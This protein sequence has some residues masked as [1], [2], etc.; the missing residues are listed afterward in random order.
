VK[1]PP[2]PVVHEINT[3]V[4]LR[5]LAVA[6]RRDVRLGDVP[7]DAW[8]AVAGPGIDAV[9]LMGVWQRSP[10][11]AA[12][13]RE[14]PAMAAAQRAALPDVTADDVVGSA[15]CIRDYVVDEH[16]GGDDGLAAARAALAARG[17]ALVLDF[18]PNH[19]APDHPW[20]LEHPERFVPGTADD[21][22]ADPDGYLAVGDAVIARGRDPYFPA[23][24]EVLQLDASRPDVR[25][26]AA[27]TVLSIAA[28]CDGVRCD[29]AMLVLDDVFARTWGAR[30]SV[31]PTADGGPGYWP[32]VIG[33]VR[34]VHPDFA[35]WAEAY[36]DLEPR[37][38]EEGFD[39]CYDK[40]LYDRLVRGEA[41]ASV[42]EHL[43]ADPASQ[44]HT[45]RFVENHDE[46]RVAS[47]LAPAAARAAAVVALTVPGVALLHEGQEVGRQV[48]VP[49][50]LGRRPDES[51]DA[52]LAAW[53][54]RLRAALATGLRRG[55]WSPAPV[56][57][58]P[59][60]RSC[61]QLVAWTW[62]TAAAGHLIVVNLSDGA[63]DG[64]IR[65]EGLRPAPVVLTDLLSA[66]RFLR[67]GAT[68]GA[69]GLYVALA[70]R[71]VHLLR[72]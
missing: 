22:A 62:V 70:P 41:A 47:V 51:P 9:W 48:K 65:L 36:W 31:A 54:G 37:L 21:L 45:V 10:V 16:L 55:G 56:E 14:H 12:I 26:A 57:G 42:R 7:D 34:A 40:R 25:E 63:A 46:P 24:P 6:A 30:A 44:A 43:A 28:R 8:D 68:A 61:E 58:W 23:W 33:A 18:V 3:W 27:T 29:M 39:A 32:T 52:D 66:E 15:Y 11:G 67:D 49:V 5:D 17:V 1:L 64:R 53:Y 60:N 72:W 19:V 4:W 38:V 50:T 2:H 71:G 13:A 35:F 59:D 69:D 20:A